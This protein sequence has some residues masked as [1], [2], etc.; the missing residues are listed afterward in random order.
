M[1]ASDP[2]R[3]LCRSATWRYCGAKG[4]QHTWIGKDGCRRTFCK[5]APVVEHMDAVGQVGDHLH[6]MLDPDDRHLQVVLDTQDEAGEVFALLSIEFG[7]RLIQQHDGRFQS[8]RAGKADDLLHTEGQGADWRVAVEKH[9]G[10]IIRN[11]S[12]TLSGHAADD[13]CFGLKADIAAGPK[14]VERWERLPASFA[15]DDASLSLGCQPSW[16]A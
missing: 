14:I 12:G 10:P 7:G 15:L 5:G 9:W 11:G 3:T 8:Q 1:S 13:V 16:I 6:V 4:G 2:Q